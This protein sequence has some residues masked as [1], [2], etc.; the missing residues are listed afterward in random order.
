MR[1]GRVAAELR[2]ATVQ[3]PVALE[4]GRRV[5]DRPLHLLD[6]PAQLADVAGPVVARGMAVDQRLECVAHLET[7]LV[8][9]APGL[10]AEHDVAEGHAYRRSRDKHPASGT[11]ARLDQAA[12]L[13]QPQ[14]L[15]HR[16]HGDAEALAQ[17]VLGPETLTRIAFID[18][19]ALE[20][21]RDQ[22]SAR[23]A[24]AEEGLAHHY[25]RPYFDLGGSD[26]A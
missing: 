6:D 11:G 7:F 13:E 8:G 5:G 20:F 15:V 12:C 9:G 18:D 19:L 16:G 22:L 1:R 2:D 26:R 23:H 4:E 17:V 3:R 14:G 24:R 21:A 25:A 10:E